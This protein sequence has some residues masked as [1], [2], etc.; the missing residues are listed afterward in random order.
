M[1]QHMEAWTK[2]PPFC[3]TFSIAIFMDFF[4]ISIRISQKFILNI[5]FKTSQHWFRSGLVVEEATCHHMSQCWPRCMTPLSITRPLWVNSLAPGKF[6]W[7]L[8]YLIS[9]IIS[10]IS[11]E[12]A[13]RW[14]SLDLTDDKSTLVQLMQRCQHPIFKKLNDFAIQP[15]KC[16]IYDKMV[17][18]LW[19]F[20]LIFLISFAYIKQIWRFAAPKWVMIKQNE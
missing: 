13:L 17:K 20:C 12:L 8:R 19:N 14:M 3:R 7:N 16:L 10:V 6:E 11:C 18:N 9:Q 15:K 2:W 4:F 1:S 5:Q